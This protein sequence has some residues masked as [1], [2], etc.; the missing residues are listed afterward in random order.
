MFL[1]DV[2]FPFISIGLVSWMKVGILVADK[3]K[4]TQRDDYI[5]LVIDFV[6]SFLIIML[7]VKS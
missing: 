1:F 4:T 2:F 6:V 3:R 5:N 7:W